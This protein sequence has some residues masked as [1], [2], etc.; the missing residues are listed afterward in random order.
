MWLL[1]TGM[2]HQSPVLPNLRKGSTA[3]PFLQSILALGFG[4]F[5]TAAGLLL[6]RQPLISNLTRNTFPYWIPALALGL[7]SWA[8][9]CFS[10]WSAKVAGSHDIDHPAG[11]STDALIPW[12]LG[13]TALLRLGLVLLIDVVKYIMVGAVSRS[14]S[15]L[16]P[17]VDGMS[18]DILR[19]TLLQHTEWRI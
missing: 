9:L 18:Q 16:T 10:E 8:I 12:S 1:G 11:H 4:A 7:T 15:R 6:F 2:H 17:N 14:T 5:L 13:N 3:R 19:L